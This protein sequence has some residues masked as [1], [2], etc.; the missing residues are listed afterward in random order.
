MSAVYGVITPPG[1]QS[2]FKSIKIADKGIDKDGE[3]VQNAVEVAQKAGKEDVE[4]VPSLAPDD[5]VSKD[6][7]AAALTDLTTTGINAIRDSIIPEPILSRRE[8]NQLQLL[9]SVESLEKDILS[10][11]PST[12]GS[13]S[14]GYSDSNGNGDRS[15]DSDIV[16]EK[17]TDV[18]SSNDEKCQ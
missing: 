11:L 7:V 14:G 17:K 6:N 3:E 1:F 12:Q 10:S 9:E 13:R 5:S 15:K 8:S 18:D 4:E 2:C 16:E